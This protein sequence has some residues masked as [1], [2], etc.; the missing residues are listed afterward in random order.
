MMSRDAVGRVAAFVAAVAVGT[1]PAATRA[2]PPRL[3]VHPDTDTVATRSEY[4]FKSRSDSLSWVQNRKLAERATGFRI[5]VSL[6][7][8]HIWAIVGVDTVLSAQAAVAKGTTLRYAG[9]KYTFDTPRGVRRVLRKEADP[10]WQPPDWLYVE[11]AAEH[12]LKLARLIR[13]RPIKIADGRILTVRD[14]VVGVIEDNEFEAL[15]VDEHVVFDNTLYIPPMGTKNRHVDGELGKFRLDLGEGY[16][17]HGTPY[18]E[19]LGMAA[20]HGCIRLSDEDIEWLYEQVPVGTRV[21][22][23]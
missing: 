18:K 16:L 5:V 9:Q 8:K 6:Q 10:V 17:L 20:T 15:P 13:G 22:I 4:S 14:S 7:D 21:Y 3:A 19:S 12:G 2:Q 1:V 23:Y 11:T